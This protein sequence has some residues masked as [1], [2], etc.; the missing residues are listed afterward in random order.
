MDFMNLTEHAIVVKRAGQSDLTIQPQGALARVASKPGKLV[1]VT[2]EG[3]EIWSA[4]EYG[5]VE[6]LPAARPN[7]TYIVS[8]E[9]ANRVVRPDVVRPGTGPHDGAVREPA[10]LPDGK[11][12]PRKGQIT[13]VTRLVSSAPASPGATAVRAPLANSE[14]LKEP[15]QEPKQGQPKPPPKAV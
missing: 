6:G 11:P 2:E 12:N 7:T 15:K 4:P 5:E 8:G 13:A 14:P 9:V 3:V 1:E 10:N